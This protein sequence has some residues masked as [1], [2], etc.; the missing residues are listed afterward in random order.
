[1]KENSRGTSWKLFSLYTGVAPPTGSYY[2][3]FRLM[4]LQN[5][6]ECSCH[7]KETNIAHPVNSKNATKNNMIFNFVLC[8]VR[9]ILFNTNLI[10]KNNLSYV[11]TVLN[12]LKTTANFVKSRYK[13]KKQFG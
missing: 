7:N 12:T 9:L 5:M 13:R 4:A 6:V 3:S 2:K 11:K 1:M 8:L 10:I